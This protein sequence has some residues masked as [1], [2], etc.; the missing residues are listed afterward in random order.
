M[1]A[2]TQPLSGEGMLT[3]TVP[4][5]A[6]EQLE[7]READARSDLFAFG[8]VLYEMVTGRRAF[9]GESQASI[10]AAIM[11]RDPPPISTLQPLTPPALDRLVR[12]CLAKDPD[13]RWQTARDLVRE[14]KWIA[15][16]KPQEAA[17]API[18]RRGR[19]LAR[20]GAGPAWLVAGVLLAACVI[21]LAVLWFRTAS[22]PAAVAHLFLPPP[23]GTKYVSPAVVGGP[24]SVSPDGRR[25][26][27]VAV[28]N[29]GVQRLWV[30]SL[31]SPVAAALAGTERA[32]FPFWSPDS[33][34]LGFF[35]PGK[36][37]RI[38]ASGGPAQEL[39]DAA[40]GR[41][42]TWNQD[43]VIVFAPRL[44]AGLLRVSDRGGVPTELPGF[45]A[46][47]NAIYPVFLPDGRHFLYNR[48]ART[49]SPGIDLSS[50]DG[51]GGQQLLIADSSNVGYSRA[52]YVLYVKNRTLVAQPFDAKGLRVTGPAIKWPTPSPTSTGR[53]SEILPSQIP[54]WRTSAWSL[55]IACD[56]TL[57]TE[58][59]SRSAP[60]VIRT[61]TTTFGSHPTTSGSC[62]FDRIRREPIRFGY[63]TSEAV[64]RL[65]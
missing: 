50:L 59:A 28:G 26:A 4:Y 57:S 18:G 30:R 24:T 42:G 33:R 19:S 52:G 14:L 6:P 65:P 9:A 7:G 31:D 36:L 21:S 58:R 35:V 17:D 51:D 46:E 20:R 53:G 39:C 12:T 49:A 44:H 40:V 10:I 43:G 23:A 2:V 15:D 13:E 8:A 61:S 38:D 22:A 63:S 55:R 60:S 11:E 48:G 25:L 29:D 34:S 27:F 1:A 62:L 45:L 47:S 16:V 54:C 41:G 64:L 5:M 56:W 32:S 3:G 37:K